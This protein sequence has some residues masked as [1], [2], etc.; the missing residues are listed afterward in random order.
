MTRLLA[1]LLLTLPLAMAAENKPP[2]VLFIF[3]DDLRVQ[4]GCYGKTRVQSPNIDRLAAGGVLFEH[5]YTSQAVCAPSRISTLTGLRLDSVGIYDLEHPFRQAHADA[6][7]LPQFFKQ[8]G[9]ETVTIGKIYHHAS[10]DQRNWTRMPEAQGALYALPENRAQVQRLHEEGKAK[11]LTG[12]ALS[13]H[14]RGP[15][16]E[17]ADVSDETYRDGVIARVAVEQLRELK[18]KPFFLCVGF[19]KP[20]L[21]FCAPK[22]YWDQYKDEPFAVPSRNKPVEMPPIALAD[23]GEMRAYSDIPKIGPVNDEQSKQLIHGYHA[24]VSYTDTQV[25]KVL[26]ELDKLGLDANTIVVLWGDHGWKL[27]EYGSWC[28]HSNFEIDTHVPL[29]IRAPGFKPGQRVSQIVEMVD[30]FPTLADLTAGTKPEQCAGTSLRPLLEG[31]GEG[32]KNFAISQY[33][34]GSEGQPVMGYS[35]RNEKW[36]Y[37][38]WIRKDG[39]LVARELYDHSTTDL[40]K[41]NVA[42]K[43]EHAELVKLLSGQLHPF[44]KTQWEG[45]GGGKPNRKPNKR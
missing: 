29:I 4:L 27:G 9:Y 33:P 22:K 42:D 18:G 32:W 24:C 37:T 35:L 28:K 12:N 45:L 30:V 10:D 3:V 13:R 15:A 8:H 23:F 19:I 6:P 25:G 36:R 34:R 40:A 1:I 21:P 38:E 2:N 44:L 31:K 39:K 16:T 5:A 43:L 41:I 11:G 20:H 7:S 14:A 26:A 17:S